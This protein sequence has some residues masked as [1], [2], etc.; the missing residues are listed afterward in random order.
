MLH[1]LVSVIIP[2]YN[3]PH[4]LVA[5]V[6]SFLLQTYQNF[7]IIVVNDGGTEEAARAISLLPDSRIRY[8]TKPNGGL[9][10]A[11]NLGLRHA[12]GKMITFCDDDDDV[13]PDRL[14]CHI[15]HYEKTGAIV[16]FC[17]AYLVTAHRTRQFFH[18][19]PTPTFSG[20]F[21]RLNPPVHAFLLNRECIA[22][23]GGFDE[24]LSH[25]HDYDLW[26]RLLSCYP[27]TYL[28]KPLI[29]YHKHHGSMSQNRVR[30]SQTIC[31]LAERYVQEHTAELSP[32]FH[33]Q[34][35]R[36]MLVRQAK[37]QLRV[38]DLHGLGTTVMQFLSQP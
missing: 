7:E 11:R 29:R 24:R 38:G 26:L 37:R 33:R 14:E 6:R 9:A 17:N 10:S 34:F 22:R 27:F 25:C 1:P 16:S 15:T 20:L 23:A 35:R 30:M 19:P 12:R 36:L 8:I 31:S 18:D 32:E 28:H 2:T 3:R 21:Y 4:H 5:A 13:L